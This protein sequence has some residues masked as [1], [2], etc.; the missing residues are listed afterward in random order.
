MRRTAALAILV[1]FVAAPRAPA[2]QDTAGSSSPLASAFLSHVRYLA[3]DALGGRGNGTEGL[4]RAADYIAAAFR[5]GGLEP[6]GERGTFFQTFAADVRVEPPAT[7]PLLVRAGARTTTM[8]LGDQYYPLSII[9]RTNGEPAP[10][11]SDAPVVFAGYGI[12][13]PA[14]GYDD[15]AGV[16]VAGKAV[17]VF[18]HE[19]QEALDASVFDGARLTPSASIASKAAEARRRGAALLI[20]ADDPSHHVDYAL[21]KDWWTDPQSDELGLPVLRVAR[22]RLAQA[23]PGIDFDAAAR[24]IDQTLT[25]ESRA[26]DGVTVSY[27]EHRAHLRPRLR[28]VVA[29]LAPVSRARAGAIVV[30]A[31]YDHL[32][33]GGRYSRAP[34]LTGVTHNGAD[35]NAS[36]TAALIEVCRALSRAAPPPSRTIVCAAFAGEE[37]GLLGS[38]HYTANAPV[39]LDQTLAMINLDM[40]GRARGRVMVGTFGAGNRLDGLRDQMRGWTRLAVEDFSR[41]GYGEHDSDSGAFSTRGVPAIA[42]FT[43]FHPDYHRPSDDWPRIDADGGARIVDLAIRLVLHLAR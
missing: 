41:G 9:N 37:L 40:V 3:S 36:G 23:L 39:P 12:T 1:L 21:R 10:S 11:V 7:A 16:D 2:R 38:E 5:A 6:A 17:V 26:L 19:P 20:V 8:A 29:R 25:P 13:A 33:T 42:L 22:V 28:N 24:R 35:D 43:G 31:H 32:G 4:E 14:L 27:T 18:T 30:G 15:Y 34:E